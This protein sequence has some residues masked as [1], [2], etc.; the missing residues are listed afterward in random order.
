M[1]P[2]AHCQQTCCAEPVAID[3]FKALKL[4]NRDGVLFDEQPVYGLHEIGGEGFV[5]INAGG[6]YLKPQ[7]GV[8]QRRR[9]KP[10]LT[11]ERLKPPL[12]GCIV[13]VEGNENG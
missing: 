10:G 5:K 7:I 8:F 12:A 3:P 4:I 13:D 6:F 2:A 9:I 11:L 1:G